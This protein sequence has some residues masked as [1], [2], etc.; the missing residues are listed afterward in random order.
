MSRGINNA[1]LAIPLARRGRETCTTN[2]LSRATPKLQWQLTLMPCTL[3]CIRAS[4]APRLTLPPAWLFT[5]N[6]CYVA[7]LSSPR[8]LRELWLTTS[9][10][11]EFSIETTAVLLLELERPERLFG[12][13]TLGGGWKV[14]VC[15]SVEQPSPALC[16]YCSLVTFGAKDRKQLN[17]AWGTRAGQPSSEY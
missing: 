12:V 5:P 13:Q 16:P 4:T 9:L 11:A 14:R 8:P 15:A 17:G 1:P 6:F 10:T 7:I 3:L 2:L